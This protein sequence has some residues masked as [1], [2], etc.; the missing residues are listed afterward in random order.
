MLIEEEDIE[1]IKEERKFDR[2]LQLRHHKELLKALSSIV[3]TLNENTDKSGIGE[4]QLRAIEEL[5]TTIR[6]LPAP[7]VRVNIE[8]EKVI[9]SLK[10]MEEGIVKE[11]KEPG[12]KEKPMQEWEFTWNKDRHGYMDGKIIAKQ[13]K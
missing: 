10:K 9:T 6:S 7:D 12:K 5:K 8:Q 3:N 2:E 11:L 13:I 1:D 4:K